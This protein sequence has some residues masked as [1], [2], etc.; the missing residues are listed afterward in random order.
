M[1]EN[2]NA[3]QNQEILKKYEKFFKNIKDETTL[4][5]EKE[6]TL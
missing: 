1:Q 5:K 3:K 6:L 2:N 4:P